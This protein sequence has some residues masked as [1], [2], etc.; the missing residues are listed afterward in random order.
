MGTLSSADQIYLGIMSS[1]KYSTFF[2][3][4]VN[5]CGALIGT[6]S[7][8]YR[9]GFNKF[10]WTAPSQDNYEI[11]LVNGQSHDVTGTISIQL[12]TTANS[13]SSSFTYTTP[14]YSSP[15]SQTFYTTPYYTTPYQT[16][17]QPTYTMPLTSPQVSPLNLYLVAGIIA[18]LAIAAVVSFIFLR[19]RGRSGAVGQQTK[20]SQFAKP[21]PA[22]LRT[23]GQQFC[24]ECG[25]E[26][27]SKSKFCNNCGTKQP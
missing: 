9:Y 14:T 5:G 15:S 3:A 1:S 26:L 6:Y 18:G 7:E 19:F 10:Q 8:Y 21:K 12:I 27:P 25:S 13:Q 23:S 20:L 4:T 22:S 17:A 16:T 2:T 11:V 24:V